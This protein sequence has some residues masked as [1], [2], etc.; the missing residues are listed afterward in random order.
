M[1]CS[2]DFHISAM[3]DTLALTASASVEIPATFLLKP[4]IFGLGVSFQKA[5]ET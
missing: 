2:R 1:P 3:R 5:R 4:G